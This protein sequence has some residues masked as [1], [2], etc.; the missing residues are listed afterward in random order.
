MGVVGLS[1]PDERYRHISINV[2]VQF[3]KCK[4]GWGVGANTHGDFDC[5]LM[6]YETD[7]RRPCPPCDYSRDEHESL[8]IRCVASRDMCAIGGPTADGI[9][10]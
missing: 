7:L 6:T 4:G 10:Q 2:L 1:I 8:I 3:E 5:I 9:C